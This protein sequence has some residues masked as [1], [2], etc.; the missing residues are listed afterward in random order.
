MA[1]KPKKKTT[2]KKPTAKATPK[3][4]PAKPVKKAAPKKAVAKKPVKKPVVKAVSKAVAKAKPKAKAAKPAV[5][6]VA[7]VAKP[8]AKKA[9]KTAASA[10][11]KAAKAV[12]KPAPAKA[13][14]KAT[15]AV[16]KKV[17]KPK[18]GKKAPAEP[19]VVKDAATLFAEQM[20]THEFSPAVASILRRG[21]S[22]GF[23]TSEDI[24]GVVGDDDALRKHINQTVKVL[25][26]EVQTGPKPS[27]NEG[28][29]DKD[30]TPDVGQEEEED[31]SDIQ[32]DSVRMYL[33][34]I[35]RVPLS[36]SNR[37]TNRLMTR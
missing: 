37:E 22:T 23:L 15:S 27:A 6:K 14:S 31:T 34:E 21:Q 28:A 18:K 5:K 35:G 16:P 3:K 2:A 24:D 20:A 30:T 36:E 11:K 8:A 4:A 10:V 29:E 7:K 32:D 12:A 19:A 13:P 9:V 25:K 17:A 33:R 26:I 1:E